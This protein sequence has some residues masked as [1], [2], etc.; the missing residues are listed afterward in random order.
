M[1]A[2]KKLV[3]NE[4]PKSPVAELFRSLRTNIQF[5]SFD[6]QI[7]TIL[8]TSSNPTEG[9]STVIS[10]LAVVMAQSDN[11]VLL[12][13][14]DLRKPNVHNFFKLNVNKGLTSL[15]T[16][17]GKVED[18]IQKTEIP[19]LDV[20]TSGPI[21]PNPSEL[22]ASIAMKKIVEELIQKYDLV[23][24]DSPPVGHVTDAVVISTFCDAS[25]LVCAQGFTKI[26]DAKK[27]KQQLESVNTNF[28][29]VVLNKVDPKGKDE[30]YYYYSSEKAL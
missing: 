6:K 30:Y 18:F 1:N 3:T 28:L 13:D 21:P 17:K 2:P 27:A 5:K 7:K 25:I 16:Q 23:L 14:G 19:G 24:F 10:N 8:V 26:E 29:G 11:K 4:Q 12:I 15:L 9:K 20:M 22:L